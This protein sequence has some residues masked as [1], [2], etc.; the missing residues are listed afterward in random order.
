M[1]APMITSEADRGIGTGSATAGGELTIGDLRH[2][3]GNGIAVGAAI[4]VGVGADSGLRA[5]WRAH[6]R[7]R[8]RAPG[9]A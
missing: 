5:S 7:C 9:R 3:G 1:P 8:E 6:F 4:T 2:L